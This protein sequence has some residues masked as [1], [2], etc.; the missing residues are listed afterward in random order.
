MTNHSS[1]FRLTQTQAEAAARAIAVSNGFAVIQR[2]AFD[3]R[4]NVLEGSP[5]SDLCAHW[6]VDAA[7]QVISYSTAYAIQRAQ[8]L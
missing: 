5:G 6:P 8:G 1:G 4:C 7:G 2:R 3:G